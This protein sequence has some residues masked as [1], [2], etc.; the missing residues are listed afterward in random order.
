LEFAP[1]KL[2][3]IEGYMKKRKVIVFIDCGST[4]NFIH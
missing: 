2:P 1:I 3:D 4:H